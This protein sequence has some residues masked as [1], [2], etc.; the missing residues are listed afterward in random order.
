MM[1]GET[2]VEFLG[3]FA[4]VFEGLELGEALGLGETKRE[5]ELQGFG[6]GSGFW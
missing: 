1:D 5:L 6:V 4:W 3:V 2:N